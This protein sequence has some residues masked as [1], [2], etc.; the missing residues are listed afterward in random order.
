MANNVIGFK[1]ELLESIGRGSFGIVYKGKNIFTQENVAV[2]IEKN[3]AK[4]K[5]LKHETIICKH[6]NNI[7]GI[8]RV[9]WFGKEKDFLYTVYDLLGKDLV[10]YKTINGVFTDKNIDKIANQLLTRLEI[11]HSKDILHRDL[12]PDN[13]LLDV[14]GLG[15][16]FI[17]DFGLSKKF[18]VNGKHIVNKGK[19]NIVGSLNFCS[20]NNMLGDECSR[21]DDL[22]SLGYILMYL[23]LENLPWEN[24][25][26]IEEIKKMKAIED[27][28]I[29]NNNLKKYLNYCYSL[30]F[31][32]RP[33]YKF[34]KSIFGYN[35]DIKF[36]QI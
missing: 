16:L 15:K 12:K 6:L 23:H 9:R 5:I 21:R 4:K 36:A 10:Y 22:I 26:N 25:E 13:V 34:L 2:K 35:G 31:S 29:S 11:I 24:E 19:K 30:N 32:E 28:K 17:I 14:N 3:T 1:Y 33:D 20:I 27:I 8:P 7:E 18:K